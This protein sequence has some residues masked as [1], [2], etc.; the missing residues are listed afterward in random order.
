MTILKIVWG[1]WVIPLLTWLGFNDIV[2]FSWRVVGLTGTRQAYSHTWCWFWLL[3]G[4]PQFQV[5]IPT[6]RI[7]VELQGLLRKRLVLHITSLPLHL[8][9]RSKYSGQE[10]AFIVGLPLQ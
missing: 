2:A 7:Q 6:E 4:A 3:A 1:D 5:S 10:N 8:T 9:G